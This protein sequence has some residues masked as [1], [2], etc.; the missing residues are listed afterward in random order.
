MLFPIYPFQFMDSGIVAELGAGLDDR[1][2]RPAPAPTNSAQWQPRRR[3][4]ISRRNKE[5]WGGAPKIDG[6]SFM[7]VPNADTALSQYDAGELDF[8][9]VHATAIRRVLRDE[10]YAK[11]LIQRAAGAVDAISA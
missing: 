8:V 7:I 2:P 3:R 11:E 9:D 1:R 4:S 10:R 5:Y 6:V